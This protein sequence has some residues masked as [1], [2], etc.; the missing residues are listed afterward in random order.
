[1]ALCPGN[2]KCLEICECT[3]I[4]RQ[5]R[6]LW[7]FCVC[8]HDRHKE[9]CVPSVCLKKCEPKRCF[10]YQ[11]CHVLTS[12]RVLDEHEGLCIYCWKY[13]GNLIPIQ[14]IKKCPLCLQVKVILNTVCRPPEIC[15]ECFEEILDSEP[16]E[17][18]ENNAIL[19]YIEKNQ[20]S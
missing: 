19:R 20:S 12:Q 15:Y 5:H 9:S 14:K 17:N 1:M 6:N 4:D 3:C 11:Y 7:R 8:D 18:M 16:E 10:N 2:G 13:Y